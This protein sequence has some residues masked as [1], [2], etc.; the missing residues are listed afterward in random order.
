[1]ALSQPFFQFGPGQN[2]PHVM[3]PKVLRTPRHLVGLLVAG[4]GQ[5]IILVM[6]LGTAVFLVSSLFPGVGAA[7]AAPGDRHH[8]PGRWRG[9]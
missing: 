2:V 4:W 3:P 6:G 5:S 9:G 1:M 8:G 7:G